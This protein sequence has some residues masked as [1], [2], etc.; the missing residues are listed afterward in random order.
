MNLDNHLEK[1][2]K[3]EKFEWIKDGTKVRWYD[4]EVEHRDLERVWIIKDYDRYLENN[5]P[6]YYDIYNKIDLINSLFYTKLLYVYIK[7]K[8]QITATSR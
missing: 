8:I 2:Y 4:P 7:C 3:E 5:Q 6:F 1:F